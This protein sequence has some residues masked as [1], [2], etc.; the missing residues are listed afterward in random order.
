ME[1]IIQTALDQAQ[2]AFDLGETPVGAVIFDSENKKILCSAHNLTEKENDATAHAEILAIREAGKLLKNTNL[3]GY[4]IFST[5]EPCAMCACA[6][7]WAKLDCVYF[8]A[9]DTKSGGIEHGAQMYTHTHHKPEVVGGLHEKECARLVSDF[10]KEKRK[11]QR[12]KISSCESILFFFKSL[13]SIV[14]KNQN[15]II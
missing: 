10:F 15:R 13:F 11:W 7:S 9:Y 1:K 14:Y 12:E 3:S 6:I 2:K 5:L 8:G 4:S